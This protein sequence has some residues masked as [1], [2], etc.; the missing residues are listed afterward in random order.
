MEKR[1]ERGEG[2]D[3]ARRQTEWIRPRTSFAL[4]AEAV[5]CSPVAV[6]SPAE[7]YAP[8]A[9]A[10]SA[11]LALTLLVL[12]LCLFDG[13]ASFGL[14]G[15]DEPRY[16]AIARE[17]A[18]TDDWV[19]PRLHGKAWFE[20]PILYYWAAAVQYKLWGDTE[21]SAR[22]PSALAAAVT[23][24]ALGWLAWRM[25]GWCAAQIVLLLFPTTVAA[26][27]FGRAATTDMLF[28]ASLALAMVTA[29]RI[30]RPAQVQA[31]DE[32]TVYAGAKPPPRGHAIIE[33][34]W[35]CGFGAAL[36]LAVLAKGPAA[37]VLTGGS[38]GLWIA[39]TRRW[40]DGFRLG[41]PV[42]MVSFVIVALPW[43]ALCALRNPD[44]VDVFLISHNVQRFL[45]PVFQHQQPLWFFGPILLLGLLPWA[46]LLFGTTLDGIRL[47]G[48]SRWMNSP[49]FFVACWAIFPVLFFSLSQS[50]LPGYVLPAIP[51]IALLLARSLSKGISQRDSQ[52]RWML[53]ATGIG[54]LLL[55]GIAATP[56]LAASG[57]PGITPGALQP[58][59]VALLV[60]GA[61]VILLTARRKLT[62]AVALSALS[63]AA[64]AG[65]LTRTVLPRMDAH[66]SARTAAQLLAGYPAP[67]APSLSVHQMHRAWHYGLNYY[68][69]RDVPVWSPEEDTAF[70]VTSEAGL[71]DL[72]ARKIELELM[73]RVSPKAIIVGRR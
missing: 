56:S 26:I 35:R 11:W 44:F 55:G 45:T 5:H 29:A 3:N 32:A 49:S 16:A 8:S 61:A 63:M 50:K 37:L 73:E 22:L 21:V 25:Y 4:G 62:Y 12:Y 2:Q 42:A 14:T 17:M 23:T 40:S 68:L 31:S 57:M 64:A 71:A 34:L 18:A 59:A 7:Q 41:H 36:G 46:P 38:A 13:L 54:L 39:A 20:K 9:P 72:R 51:P 15:P 6:N 67:Q 58:V 48:S 30:V 65:A 28:T 70:I 52:S 24:L 43:Y 53:A 60:G 10:K 33:L 19:T 66:I 47:V 69:R 1:S 27:G